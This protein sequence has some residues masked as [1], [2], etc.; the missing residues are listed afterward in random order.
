[1][2][3]TAPLEATV[4]SWGLGVTDAGVGP[5]PQRLNSLE[6]V[7]HN[8]CVRTHGHVGKTRLRPRPCQV[9]ARGSKSA[10]STLSRTHARTGLR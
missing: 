8:V 3:K 2:R 5:P 9:A 6:P 7:M 1:M 4:P 10:A